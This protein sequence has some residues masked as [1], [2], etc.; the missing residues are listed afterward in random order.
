MLAFVKDC[1]VG[2][3]NLNQIGVA[4]VTMVQ[5]LETMKATYGLIG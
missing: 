5:L 4:G 1:E 2:D 3:V